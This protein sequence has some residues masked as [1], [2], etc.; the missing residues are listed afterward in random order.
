V[1]SDGDRYVAYARGGA[2]KLYDSRRNRLTPI[3][4]KC[5]PLSGAA[6]RF[7]LACD[8]QRPDEGTA[9]LDAS[10]KTIQPL[11]TTSAFTTIGRY[12]LLGRTTNPSGTSDVYLNWRTGARVEVPWGS[13]GIPGYAPPRNI[14]SPDLEPA[15]AGGEPYGLYQRVGDLELRVPRNKPTTARLRDVRTGRERLLKCSHGCLDAQLGA[16]RVSWIV[17][18]STHATDSYAVNVY[19]SKT[20]KTTRWLVS[21]AISL[22]GGSSA[23]AAHTRQRALI[24]VV[25]QVVEGDHG[26]SPVAYRVYSAQLSSP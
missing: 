9:I 2:L 4:S 5:A 26:P 25:S 14:N 19:D 8:S 18:K 17:L 24:S 1:V 13:S 7:L 16:G 12:W 21:R 20:R 11:P 10:T 22:E 3:R 15:P 23:L 6:A